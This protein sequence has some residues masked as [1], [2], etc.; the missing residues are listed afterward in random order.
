MQTIVHEKGSECPSVRNTKRKWKKKI[1]HLVQTVALIVAVLE[2]A[3]QKQLEYVTRISDYAGVRH[4][5]FD[6]EAG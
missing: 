5:G 3:L 2:T 1:T 4:G 6:Y